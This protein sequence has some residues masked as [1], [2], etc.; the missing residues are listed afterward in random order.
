MRISVIVSAAAIS[1]LGACGESAE[2]RIEKQAEVGAAV[3]GPA[4]V[5]LGLTEAQ[6]IDAE[7]LGDKGAELGDVAAV[8]RDKNGKVDR[9]L[10]AVEDS[11]PDRFVHVPVTGLTPI[12]HGDGI[13]LSSPLTK[14][15][16]ASMVEVK[17]AHPN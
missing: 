13:K 1:I 4:K 5:A 10:I 3:S 11:Q 7:L 2:D 15:N 8:V 14:A 17:T 9:L 6:L 16:V 12:M